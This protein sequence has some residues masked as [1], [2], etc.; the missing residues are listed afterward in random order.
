MGKAR[1]AVISLHP[2][3]K[4]LLIVLVMALVMFYH[5]Y[6][7]LPAISLNQKQVW[8]VAVFGLDSDPEAWQGKP[9]SEL[10]LEEVRALA[11]AILLVH[12]DT[13]TN[14]VKIVNVPRDTI[15]T[16][17]NIGTTK[18]TVAFAKGGLAAAKTGLM[19][20]IP[21]RFE[22][23]V[24]VSYEA[25]K[26]LVDAIG[27]VTIKVEDDLV[28]PQGTVWLAKGTH[29]LDGTQAL[30]FVRHRFGDPLGD[31]GRIKRQQAFLHAVKTQ[32]AQL[33]TFQY[34][35][36]AQ[37][38]FKM[39]KTDLSIKDILYLAEYFLVHSPHLDFMVLPGASYPPK[40]HY[41]ADETKVIRQVLPFLTSE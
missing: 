39:V 26:E 21:W 18:I 34:Y 37:I 13:N 14:V 38:A 20:I 15:V 24:L 8:N 3:W 17:P 2:Y 4:A 41:Y 9:F 36:V 16:I 23:S 29:T 1:F 31:L 33:S 35:Q 22:H 28:T 11:D 12:I 32:A 6:R 7:T 30:R 40:W 5:L 25:F 10:K 27:G 19:K